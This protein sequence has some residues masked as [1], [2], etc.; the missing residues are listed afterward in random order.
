MVVVVVVRGEEDASSIVTFA[1]SR[2]SGA[3]SNRG[4]PMA[5]RTPTT[6]RLLELEPT[7]PECLDLCYVHGPIPFGQA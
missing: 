5:K 7:P 2:K 3:A 6:Y 1:L 4:Q